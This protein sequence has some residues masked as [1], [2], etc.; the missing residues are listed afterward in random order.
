M[1][2]G[3]PNVYL[4]GLGGGGLRDSQRAHLDRH[5]IEEAHRSRG[6]NGR[7]GGA[8]GARPPANGLGA[9]ELVHSPTPRH[10][11]RHRVSARALSSTSHSL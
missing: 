11:L 5:V 1:Y 8:S 9:S 3:I 6:G 4:C 2:Y 10:C 7:A